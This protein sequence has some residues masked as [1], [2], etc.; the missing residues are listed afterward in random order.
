MGAAVLEDERASIAGTEGRLWE[1][2]TFGLTGGFGRVAV[3]VSGTAVRLFEDDH[4]FGPPEEGTAPSVSEHRRDAGDVRVET[5]VRLMRHAPFEGG[6]RLGTR[7]PTTDDEVGLERDRTDFWA[8]LGGGWQRGS[9]RIEGEAGIAIIATREE[10]P[11]QVDP[12]IGSLRVRLD[13]STLEPWIAAVWQ[14]D[15]RSGPNVR[16]VEDSRE[17]RA[18]FG[19]GS[20]WRLRFE[21]LAGLEPFDPEWGVGVAVSR[22]W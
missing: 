17:L 7:L 16:G 18:G 8:T 10:A 6:I 9:L 20:A 12:L 1:V 21:G 15:T 5:I 11:E 22:R 13:G 3:R 2:G 4:A 19:V 14:H